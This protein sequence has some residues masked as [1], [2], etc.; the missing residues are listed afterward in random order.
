MFRAMG[1]VREVG[2]MRKK[3]RKERRNEGIK[4]RRKQE[5]KEVQKAWLEQLAEGR[6]KEGSKGLSERKRKKAKERLVERRK[7]WQMQKEARKS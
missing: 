3:G 6:K 7:N 1:T 4:D 5:K 2:W